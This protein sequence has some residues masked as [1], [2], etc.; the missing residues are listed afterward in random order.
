M[1]GASHGGQD[2]RSARTPIRGGHGRQTV[3]R[4][5][6]PSCRCQPRDRADGVVMA[7]HDGGRH[8]LD[9]KPQ[10]ST[11]HRTALNHSCLRLG[12]LLRAQCGTGSRGALASKPSS[13]SVG[14]APWAG[15][16]AKP[17]A[18]PLSLGLQRPRLIRPHVTD[19]IYVG[20]ILAVRIAVRG[21]SGNRTSG[22]ILISV[23]AGVVTIDG[24]HLLLCGGERSHTS[25]KDVV[26]SATSAWPGG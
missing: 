3:R 14:S 23:S 8:Q 7:I 26:T 6:R 20:G 12:D 15:L 18:L 11:I 10:V 22:L 21:A 9:A 24:P 4:T 2:C 17:R 13:S 5:R 25:V 19:V 16:T 1:Q